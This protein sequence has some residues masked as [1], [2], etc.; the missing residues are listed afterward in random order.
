[1][2]Y[3]SKVFLS[4][5]FNTNWQSKIIKRFKEAFIYFNPRE[6]GLKESC[7]YTAWDLHFVRECDIVFAYMESSNPSGFGIALEVGAASILGKTIILVDEKSSSDEVFAK[8]FK[9]VQE[10]SSVVFQNFD[11]G[12]AY[13]EKYKF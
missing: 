5:G 7:L 2:G 4:G 1:M 3:K 9:I 8:Y 10:S 11:E 13:L 12:I 6:H